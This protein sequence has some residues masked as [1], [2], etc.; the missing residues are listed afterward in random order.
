M[1][2]VLLINIADLKIP[3]IVSEHIVN[4]LRG[5]EISGKCTRWKEEIILELSPDINLSTVTLSLPRVKTTKIGD[6][7]YWSEG[8]ALC[9]FAGTS[10]PY[11]E[12]TLVGL[13]IASPHRLLER[14][15]DTYI[16]SVKAELS[17]NFKKISDLLGEMRYICSCAVLEDGECLACVKEMYPHRLFLEVYAEENYVHICTGPVLS[18]LERNSRQLRHIAEILEVLGDIRLDTDHYGNIC[19]S[20]ITSKSPSDITRSVC[21]LEHAYFRVIRESV[22]E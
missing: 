16:L 9:I 20:T 18:K 12:A 10:Q 15:A 3:V 22:R 13:T 1:S 17:E 4:I 11:C 21:K 2:N 7:L 19:L 14:A 5:R 8:N 6:V